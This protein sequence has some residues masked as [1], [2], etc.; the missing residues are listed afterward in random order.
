M[1]PPLLRPN[2][3]GNGPTRRQMRNFLKFGPKC[4]VCKSSANLM[5]CSNCKA[6]YYCS[7]AHQRADWLN[8]RANCKPYQ[9]RYHQIGPNAANGNGH[10]NGHHQGASTSTNGGRGHQEASPANG[11]EAALPQNVFLDLPPPQ[12]IVAGDSLPVAEEVDASA[13]EAAEAAAIEPAAIEAA[14]VIDVASGVSFQEAAAQL[15]ADR[16]KKVQDFRNLT[17]NTM[18]IND[19]HLS[20]PANVMAR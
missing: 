18:R 9:A 10:G 8:H 3:N 13:R 6:A 17:E 2:G 11:Q 12:P 14:A 15:Q 4:F 16:E 20:N 5:R 7:R 19:V 1:E